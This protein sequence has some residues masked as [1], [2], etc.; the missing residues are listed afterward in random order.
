MTHKGYFKPSQPQK[1]KGNSTNIIWR[2]SW[3]FKFMVDLDRDANVEWWQSE[4]IFIPYH[5]KSRGRLGHYY[6]DFLVKYKNSDT[7]VLVEIK[8]LK[9]TLPPVPSNNKKKLIKEA[10][11]YAK[12]TSKW[13]AAERYCK[14]RGWKFLKLT[15][16]E[17]GLPGYIK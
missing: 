14:Q 2:S 11:T 9:E 12:N 8:P 13:E 17:L 6:P 3:E 5:D 15:E 16:I 7:P 1:Y 4:E 10:L